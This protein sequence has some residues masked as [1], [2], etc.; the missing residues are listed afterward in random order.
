MRTVSKARERRMRKVNLPAKPPP[1]VRVSQLTWFLRYPHLVKF[2]NPTY[3]KHGTEEK[4]RRFAV[5]KWVKSSMASP[6]YVPPGVPISEK[7]SC[8]REQIEC[9]EKQSIQ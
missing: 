9:R 2:R 7:L 5:L 6:R 3:W 1:D 8:A 4:L